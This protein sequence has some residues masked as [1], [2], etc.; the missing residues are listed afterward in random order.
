MPSHQD[1]DY[2][3]LVRADRVHIS[4]YTDPLVFTDEMEKIFHRGWVYVG[5]RGEIPNRGD[6]RLKRIG[7]QPV[8]I[9]RDQNGEIQLLLTVVAIAEQLSARKGKETPARFAAVLWMDLSA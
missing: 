3:S 9:V 6:F 8:I 2:D 4:L 5:H 7:L 1:I